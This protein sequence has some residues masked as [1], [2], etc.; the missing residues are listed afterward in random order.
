MF[1]GVVRV[2]M[3]SL[4]YEFPLPF[5]LC[6]KSPGSGEGQQHL[7]IDCANGI[8]ALKLSEMQPYLPKE[9]LVHIYNDGTKEKLNHLCGADFVKVHQ[10]PPK[11][12]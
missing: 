5:F 9:V 12:T 1:L 4:G 7:K 3:V 10:K 6:V 11:G 2:P 8:G